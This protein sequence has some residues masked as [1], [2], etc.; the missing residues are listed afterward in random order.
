ME[1]N[2]LA[3]LKESGSNETVKH[4]NNSLYNRKQYPLNKQTKKEKQLSISAK[5]RP[6]SKS[7]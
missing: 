2:I 3:L 6:Q 4:K 5:G 1:K 7:E